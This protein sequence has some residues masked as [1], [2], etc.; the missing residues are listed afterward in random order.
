M[1]VHVTA[2]MF[3][4]NDPLHLFSADQPGDVRVPDHL[5][6]H[7]ALHLCGLPPA[8]HQVRHGQWPHVVTKLIITIIPIIVRPSPI[9]R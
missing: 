1:G 2:L 9:N 4:G 8:L 7:R 5:R 3:P 6:V